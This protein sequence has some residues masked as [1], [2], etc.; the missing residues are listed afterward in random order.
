MKHAK[1]DDFAPWR[2][3]ENEAQVEPYPWPIPQLV[4]GVCLAGCAYFWYAVISAIF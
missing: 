3:N 1:R 2:P 4:W